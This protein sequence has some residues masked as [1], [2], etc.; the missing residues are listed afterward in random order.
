MGRRASGLR[1]GAPSDNQAI[2]FGMISAGK[3]L[4]GYVY[5]VAN[6]ITKPIRNLAKASEKLAKGEL[7]VAPSR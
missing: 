2:L 3:L 5:V 7:D 6:S 4:L 1:R